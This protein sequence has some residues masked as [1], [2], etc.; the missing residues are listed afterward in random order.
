M[1]DYIITIAYTCL[2]SGFAIALAP[3]GTTTKYLKLAVSLVM[4]IVVISPVAG[5]IENISEN[6]NFSGINS[7][8]PNINEIEDT[9]AYNEWLVKVTEERL[10]Q[11]LEKEIMNF[12]HAECNIVPHLLFENDV[13]EVK[14]ID[15]YTDADNTDEIIRYLKHNYS[16]DAKI[17]QLP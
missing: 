16:L 6:L 9:D 8:T 7:D 3:K 13:M 1:K 17:I 5:I 4:L 2:I 11:T 14:G 12:C 10:G 15:I